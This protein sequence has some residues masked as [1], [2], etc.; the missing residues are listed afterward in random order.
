MAGQDYLDLNRNIA[1]NL[2]GDFIGQDFFKQMCS[3]E[4]ILCVINFR[5]FY[6]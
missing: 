2:N 4:K 1:E 3:G 5:R 6:I